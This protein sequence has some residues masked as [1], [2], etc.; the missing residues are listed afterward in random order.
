MPWIQVTLDVPDDLTDAVIGE[1]S[2]L[3]AAGVW[4]SAEPAPGT[5]RMVAY[6]DSQTGIA[7]VH[8]SIRSVFERASLPPPPIAHDNVADRDWNEEWKR[9]YA[10]FAI[11]RRFFVIPSW[12]G[13]A[14][15]PGRLPVLIDPGQA[16]GTGTHETTQLTLEA[17]EPRIDPDH[18]ILDLGTGSGL[19][20]IACRKLGAGRT[21]ACDNDPIA[22]EVARENLERNL[23]SHSLV[24]CGSA[25]A[26]RSE[27]F[28][29]VLGNLTADVIVRLIPEVARALRR[30]GLAILSGILV[31]QRDD[32]LRALDSSV[33]RVEEETARGEWLALVVRKHGG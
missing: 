32:V 33:W 27:A 29:V 15:P 23:R 17:L 31:T 20:A 30:G 16:F 9:S 14:C 28:D 22:C 10:S 8:R 12:S 11:G 5:A 25:G 1:L 21:Y 19:L 4:E 6:F 18:I 2:M 7:E 3:G 13:D 26:F 24:V